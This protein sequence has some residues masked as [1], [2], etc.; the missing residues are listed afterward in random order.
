MKLKPGERVRIV[1]NGMWPN[2]PAGTMATV[3]EDDGNVVS[4]TIDG[5][6][7]GFQTD[8]S[9]VVV[10]IPDEKCLRIQALGHVANCRCF[11]PVNEPN[12]ASDKDVA[13]S[14]KRI[15]KDHRELLSA[16]VENKPL[17]RAKRIEVLLIE[18]R[19]A[20]WHCVLCWVC[21]QSK[22]PCIVDVT[23]P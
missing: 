15:T 17:T 2:M 11:K 21:G 10:V 9:N 22:P 12:I 16:L 5:W 7:G 23:P 6:G 18:H 8:S 14:I 1:R 13:H 19:P 20:G 4:L 3:V